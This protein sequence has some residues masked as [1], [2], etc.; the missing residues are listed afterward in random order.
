MVLEMKWNPY[1][2]GVVLLSIGLIIIVVDVYSA[3]EVYNI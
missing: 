1:L 2:V 3:Y